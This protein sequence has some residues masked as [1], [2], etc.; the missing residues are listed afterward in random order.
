[1]SSSSSSSSYAGASAAASAS[2]ASAAAAAAVPRPTRVSTANVSLIDTKALEDALNKKMINISED[3][4]YLT[5]I[6]KK[7]NDIMQV[8]FLYSM[9][10]GDDLQTFGVDKKIMQA[11]SEI[12]SIATKIWAHVVKVMTNKTPSGIISTYFM[13]HDGLSIRD[14][15]HCATVTQIMIRTRQLFP[16]RIFSEGNPIGQKL[17]AFG[18]TKDTVVGAMKHLITRFGDF[19]SHVKDEQ[20]KTKDANN[21]YLLCVG[22]ILN[23]PAGDG[24][25]DAPEVFSHLSRSKKPW[26]DLIEATKT[27]ASSASSAA[28]HPPA[29]AAA[30]GGAS[31]TSATGRYTTSRSA[32]RAVP[33]RSVITMPLKTTSS[34]GGGTVPVSIKW[35]QHMI[36]TLVYEKE[37]RKS[38]D[39]IAKT[40]SSTF[41]IEVSEN[42]VTEYWKKLTHAKPAAKS[43][44]NPSGTIAA[45][46]A[47]AASTTSATSAASDASRAQSESDSDDGLIPGLE[48]ESKAFKAKQVLARS[49]NPTAAGSKRSG[50][51]LINKRRKNKE[52][53]D[54]L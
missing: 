9:F 1:M 11:G 25:K 17:Y 7:R 4:T 16:P 27:L 49:Q 22:K 31:T 23:G 48:N 8:L 40:I 35:T 6:A 52:K 54:K 37:Q 29:A 26:D 30:A 5:K 38:F 2:P 45:A 13:L 43:S 18:V 10:R 20:L 15:I 3:E 44:S 14:F 33:S 28:P 50:E 39:D 21:L 32:T 34:V 24:L 46:A 12:Q 41:R 42:D 51:E 53:N 47:A 36:N 19:I